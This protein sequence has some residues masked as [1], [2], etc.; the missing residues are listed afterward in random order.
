VPSLVV[1]AS[2]A[3]KWFNPAE[4]LADRAN[5]IRDDYVHGRIALVERIVSPLQVKPLAVDTVE[6]GRTL[7]QMPWD[8]G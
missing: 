8:V 4:D 6:A 7:S 2:V 3:I 5:L 1:D